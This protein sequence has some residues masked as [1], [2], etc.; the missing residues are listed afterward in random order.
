VRA[1]RLFRA[2]GYPRPV[3]SLLVG[4]C[5][6]QTPDCVLR[7]A[8]RPADSRSNELFQLQRRLAQ[9][10]LPQGAPTSPALANLT[11]WSLDVRLTNW[12]ERVG[13]TYSRYAD[14]LVFSGSSS[15]SVG[16][17]TRAVTDICRDEGFRVNA[18][19]TRVMRAHQRQQVTGLVV[20]QGV[21]VPRAQR[22]TLEAQLFNLAR[23]R[24]VETDVPV[25]ALRAHLE[26][27][28]SWVSHA[29][30]SHARW[31]RELLGRID[32]A[33]LG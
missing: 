12:A 29:H 26:G 6:T 21:A 22:D 14:D 15:L 28:V 4:L 19:K 1:H 17:L 8:P 33:A 20:N 10:H 23:G 13:A 25:P 27:K 16:G 31:L 24:R 3:A 11:C 7:A 18:A 9:S 30:P 5:T 2:L 32:W